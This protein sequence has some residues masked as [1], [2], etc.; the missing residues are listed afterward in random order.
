MSDEVPS[1]RLSQI[2]DPLT[3]LQQPS[4]SNSS[5]HHHHQHYQQQQ[6]QRTLLR[7]R[8]NSSSPSPSTSGRAT[9]ASLG[10]AS[11]GSAGSSGSSS[12]HHQQQQHQA[13]QQNYQYLTQT[14]NYFLRSQDAATS[15]S[16]G[17]V[18]HNYLHTFPSAANQ[19]HYFQQQQQHYQA[20]YA[21]HHQQPYLMSPYVQQQHQQQQQQQHSL[22]PLYATSHSLNSS[23]LLTKRAISFS[24]NMPLSR[25]QMETGFNS[26]AAAFQRSQATAQSTP[27]S[28]R[29]MP[30]R[31]QKPPPIPAKPNSSGTASA[32]GPPP[33]P[34][35]LPS[36]SNQNASLKDQ[37]NQVNPAASLDGADA[38]W[39]HFSSLTEYLDVHQVN[40]YTQGVPEINWQER[41]LEL[42]LELHRSK[43]QA[44]RIRDML[45]EKLLE[46]EQRVIEAEER[47]EEAEDKVRAMEQR[48]SEWPKPPTTANTTN[49]TNQQQGLQQ[50][51]AQQQQPQT[52]ANTSPVT[53]SQQQQSTSLP[54]HPEAE[55]VITSLEIQVEEQRQL[56]LQ[57]ARQIEAKAA[58]IKEWVNNKLRDLEEQ[59]ELLREQNQ[60]CNQQLELLKNYIANQ[61]NRHSVIGPVRNSLSLDVQEF[62]ASKE[63]RRRSESLDT[64]E[65]INRPLTASYPHHQHRRNLSME[66]TE[67]ERNLVAAVDGLTLAPLASISKQSSAASGGAVK[68]GRPDSSDTDT[69]HDYAEIYTPSCEKM[70]AWMKNNPALMAS[71]GTSTTTTTSEI[72][73]VPRPP[74]PPL[75]RF[76]SWEAK[77][78]QVANDGLAGASST[79]NGS[80]GV[81]AT[82]SH[83]QPPPPDIQESASGV[84]SHSN[85]L[86][87]VGHGRHTPASLN[88]GGVITPGTPQMP[89]R[90]QQTASGGFCD[91]SVPVYATVKGRASQIRSMPFTG[92]SS[93]DSSDGEDHAV[94][95]T[96]NS[97]NSSS[98][99]NTETS[100]SGSA[101]S[102]SKSC[103]T[104]SSLS[105]A[106]RSGSESPKNTKAR[107]NRII[108]HY[109]HADDHQRHDQQQQQHHIRNQSPS[110]KLHQRKKQ[111]TLQN[112]ITNNQHQQNNHHHNT[113]PL[114]YTHLNSHNHNS[115]LSPNNTNALMRK[116]PSQT[117]P[118]QYQKTSTSANNHHLRIPHQMRGTVISDISFESGLS[119]DYA[120]PPDA[121]SESTCPM[122][123][124]MPSLLMRQSYV[125]SPSK[126]LESLEKAGHLAK[127]GGKLKTWRKRW[128]VLKNGTLTYWKSQH[129]INRKP[130]GQIML[131]E[132]CRISKAEGASTF[133]IDTGKKVYYLT[134][135][136]NATMDDWIRVL[137]NVQRRNATKLLLSRED[138]KP[139]LQGWVTKVKN[140]HAKKCW[141]VLLGKM[142]LYFKA[143]NETNPLGQ[144]NM[145]DARVEEVEHVSDSDSEERED[146]Q[147]Q[148][149]LTVAIYPAHQGPTYLILPNKAER[150]NWL[151]NL[152]VVSGG[153]PSAGTQ[154]EQLVQKLMETDGDPN[155]VIWRHPILLHTKDT[156]SAPMCTLHT[157]S[158]HQEAI[159][160]FKSIQLF[161]SV[162]VNQPGIDYHVVLA[163]NALQHCLDMPE[164][165]SEMFCILIK[166]TSRHT[167]QKLSVGVQQLLL[168]ATQSLFACDTQQSGNAQAN[169]SSPTSL[170]APVPPPIIDCKSNPPAY[171]FV[172]GWQLLALAVS[173]FVPKSSRLLWYLKLHLSRNADTKTETGKYAAYCERALERTLKNGGRETKPSRMEVLSILLKNP[174]HHSLPHAIPVHM[175]NSTYQVVSFDG[176][177]TIEEFQSTLAQEIGTRD[178]SNGFCLFSDDP[179]EKDLEHYLDPMAKLCDVI[180]KWETALREKGSGKFENTR[181]IQLTYKNRLYWK[182]TVKFETDKE[183][184]LLCYQTNSQIVQGRFPLSRDLALELASLMAQIDMGDYSHEKSKSATTNVGIKA[185]DKFYPYRY[186]DALNPDQLKDIQES[187]ITKWILLKGR[188]TLDCVRI[189]LTCCRKWPYFGASLF[190]AKPRH[191]DQAMAWLAVS[192][193]ALNVL[194]LSTMAPLARYPYTSVMTFGG[195]QDDFMLVVSNE[196]TL[197]SCGSHEQKLLFAMSKPK[198]LEITLLIADYMN[199]LG[200][201]V[202]GTPHM[203]SLTRNGSH[204]SIRSRPPGGT[205]ATTVGGT[206]CGNTTAGMSTNATTTAH[207]TLNSHATH[208]L[209]S[210][211]SHTLSSSHYSG[212]DHGGGGGT[213]SQ[214]GSHQGTLNSL[215]SQNHHHHHNPHQPD[216]LKS[217]PDHQRIK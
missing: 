200:H 204:R 132:A 17:A 57:D 180:S 15:S 170:Q 191:S 23:P 99:D 107:V 81:G 35:S 102:P 162:A 128:F 69:A 68:N 154:Y 106:K 21:T 118:A 193:D 158:M 155:C 66:P 8:S 63:N 136:S 205:G 211:H 60:K 177:T 111:T 67:L 79:E 115:H 55:K 179:I 123:A 46:L 201:T 93:D 164:L 113:M 14:H 145:R 53:A 186:R 156:I 146:P 44:G 1:G 114:P 181:V 52:P 56:R 26:P 133:E 149:H 168:C 86:N 116:S 64:Q 148:A 182:H 171:S 30:R 139:T 16:G 83:S 9:P 97:H 72:G 166:Q 103:K 22:P 31:T 92:D 13:F 206:L 65:I 77:I 33:Q 196:D 157:E 142:F 210:N 212:G 183:R 140:G 7:S 184:L 5:Q 152:T 3:N 130:Q 138:Q 167:G 209:N 147:S 41:C 144:I 217:T 121:V 75:H 70:P 89:T 126:K 18:G 208:T 194:E 159:K 19:S 127:L 85:T 100:T 58:K 96:H 47:A 84:N 160:L 135:D 45:R 129:D 78:Y 190:Q 172:Q 213:R 90:Q 49:S 2:F 202:P 199:A 215:H 189:Y 141:C 95:L 169:G 4:S 104:S 25:Q 109:K 54:A 175:M 124:S 150:D 48:L 74:T 61:S 185:L 137:Q 88:D 153:G 117:N 203:N 192:E 91:I 59:N 197:A 94:M 120:L 62:A 108:H 105:P 187:L 119:D 131:D 34:P 198:I 101:S 163:Q 216:I 178:A 143:P 28:P 73:G 161:M 188:S 87:N 51:Q 76:P 24:G 110:P 42:Q 20:Q 43:N 32:A 36:A 165:H 134:A 98:T 195:C 112:T 174:Y 37:Q 122:D 39:P 12:H 173:L 151:Y 176:S 82:S 80:G 10:A 50:Q 207:N 125:D 11:A 40:N 214:G 6:Q 38:P 71:G 27:N 29:L